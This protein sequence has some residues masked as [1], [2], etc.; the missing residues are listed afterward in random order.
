VVS[1]LALGVLVLYAGAALR[2]FWRRDLSA[3]AYPAPEAAE[4]E[5]EALARD[6][7]AL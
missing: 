1:W 4:A 5:I 7:P 2:A 6:H 3:S